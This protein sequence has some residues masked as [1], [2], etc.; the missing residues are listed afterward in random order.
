V[1]NSKIWREL[2]VPLISFVDVIPGLTSSIA[3]TMSTHTFSPTN[4]ITLTRFMLAE[5]AAVPD[6]QGDLT[7]LL[8]SVQVSSQ[9]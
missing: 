2:L 4:P 7:L 8:T 5:Q 9:P 3:T 1:A 6:A